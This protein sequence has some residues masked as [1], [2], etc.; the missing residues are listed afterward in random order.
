[1][2]E[3]SVVIEINL[4]W[5]ALN[6][7]QTL[8][9]TALVNTTQHKNSVYLFISHPIWSQGSSSVTM[10]RDLGSTPPMTLDTPHNRME[11]PLHN[12]I[13]DI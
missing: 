12:I 2:G 11:A 6:K 10:S 5:Y 4:M 3:Q 13:E 1:M 7:A 8:N 9:D